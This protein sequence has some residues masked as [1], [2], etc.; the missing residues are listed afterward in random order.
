[1]HEGKLYFGS[2]DCHFYCIDLKGKEVWRF[3]TSSGVKWKV[4]PE[5]EWFEFEVDIKESDD[6]L[7]TEYGKGVNVA[8]EEFIES[9]YSLK[10]EYQ[11]KSEYKTESEYR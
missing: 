1:M 6:A 2:F 8:Q 3:K 9:E 11:T 10:S 5:S 7:K 4:P